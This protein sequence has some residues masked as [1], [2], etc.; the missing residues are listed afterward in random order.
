M[1]SIGQFFSRHT[2]SLLISLSTVSITAFAAN[3]GFFLGGCL[4]VTLRSVGASFHFKCN[5]I[6]LPLFTST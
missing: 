3:P 6:S 2:A 1:L 4:Q 5:I